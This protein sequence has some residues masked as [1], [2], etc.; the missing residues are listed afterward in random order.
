MMRSLLSVAP[1]LASVALL[2][3]GCG[4]LNMLLPLRAEHEGFGSM[5]IGLLGSAQSLGFIAGCLWGGRIIVRVGHIRT[6]AG[7]VGLVSCLFL[8]HAIVVEPAVWWALRA[9]GGACF[10]TIFMVIESW[11]NARADNRTRGAVFCAYAVTCHLSGS[12]GHVFVSVG[13][14]DRFV[15]FSIGSILVSLAAL[16]VA[17]SR[18]QAP[19]PSPVARVRLLKL[20]RASPVGVVG[21][22]VSGMSAGALLS[23]AS[24]E[25]S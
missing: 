21:C 19:Q 14:P 18:C 20:W 5:A 16:P 6:F 25:G 1:L 8:A 10:S 7:L 4:V 3:A 13:E 9:L 11:L 17:L 15:L 22:A 24:I 2:V 12:I 23:R